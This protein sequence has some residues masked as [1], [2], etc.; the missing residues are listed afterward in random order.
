MNTFVYRNARRSRVEA[1]LVMLGDAPSDLRTL[2]LDE[3]DALQAE[4]WSVSDRTYTAVGADWLWMTRLTLKLQVDDD[5]VNLALGEPARLSEAQAASVETLPHFPGGPPPD[6]LDQVRSAVDGD[7]EILAELLSA[8][9]RRWLLQPAAERPYP[10]DDV[11]V[12][13]P[14]RLETLFDRPASEYN[15][16]PT[17]WRLSLRVIPDEASICRD[18]AF[19]SPDERKAATAFWNAVQQPGDPGPSWLDGEDAAVAWGQFCARVTPARAAWLIGELDAARVGE[20]IAVSLPPAMPPA[21]QPNRVGG[22]PPEL[23]VIITTTLAV[24]GLTEHA[25]GRLPMAPDQQI[26]A[27]RL[28]LPVPA[29]LDEERARWWSNWAEAKAVGL[30]GEWLLPPGVTPQNIETL[31]VVGIGDERPEA[32][33]KA[34]IDA[35]ELGVLRLGAPTNT[36]HGRPA[37]DLG[38]ANADWLAVAQARLRQKAAPEQSILSGVGRTL[39]H[40]LVGD[41][42]DLPFFPGADVADDTTLSQSMVKAL[43]PALWGQWMTQLWQLDA[44][45]YRVGAWMM[46]HFCPEGPLMPLRIGE[47]PYGL[48]PVTALSQWRT[49]PVFTPEAQAQA[50]VESAMAASLHAVCRGLAYDAEQRR[51]AM[52]KSTASFMQNLGHTALSADYIVRSFGPAWAFLA[53]LAIQVGLNPALFLG[54]QA[55]APEEQPELFRQASRAYEPARALMQRDP[56]DI[57]LASGDGHALDMPLVQPPAMTYRLGFHL[58]RERYELTQLLIDVL[59]GRSLADLFGDEFRLRILPYSLLIRLL[60]HAGQAVVPWRQAAELPRAQR[61]IIEEQE[62]STL[63]IGQWLDQPQWHGEEVDPAT[64]QVRSFTLNLPPIWRAD[65]ERALRATLDSASY[66]IDPWITGFAWQRLKQ[67]SA[68]PRR[69]QRL[70]VYGW[71]DGPFEGA[72]GPNEY[73]RLHTPSYNQT[74]AA[75]ILRD[76]FLSAQRLGLN[77]EDGDNPWAMNIGS[78]SVRL[79]EEIAD[80]VRMG[81][82][83]YEIV[84]RHVEHV[85]ADQPGGPEVVRQLRLHPRYAMRPERQ[86]PHEVCNGIAALRSLLGKD[87]ALPQGD[88]VFPLRESQRR[89]LQRIDAALDAY[90]DLL[91]AD[92]TMQLVNRQPERA[93]ESMDAASGFTRPPAFEFTRTPPSGY[94]LESLVLC[95]LP[96]RSSAGLGS[97]ADPIR[98]ADASVA[99][100][101]DAQLGDGWLWRAYAPDD[102]ETVIGSI[103]LA[104]LGFAPHETLALSEQM[105]CDLAQLR[106]G[107]VDVR[108]AAPRQHGLAQEL[109]RAL[110]SRPLAG[111]DLGGD[112]KQQRAADDLAYRELRS[113]YVRLYRNCTTLATRLRTAKTDGVRATLLR[114]A[115]IWGVMPAAETTDRDALYALLAGQPLPPGSPTTATL[116]ERAAEVLEQ[117][118]RLAP[119]PTSL[120]SAAELARPLSDDAQ[121]KLDAIPDGIPSLATAIANLASPNGRLAILACW[122]R[123]RLLAVS[124]LEIGQP[125]TLLDE[126]WLTVTAATRA[127]LA[128]LEAIQLEIEP[129]LIAWSSSPG[130]PWQKTL[131]AENLTRRDTPH[132]KR[133]D[134]SVLGLVTRPFVAGYGVD[135]AWT[136][137]RVAAGMIDAFG[138][139]IPMPQRTSTAAFGFNAPAARPPQAI[140]LAVPPTPRQRLEN[141]LLHRIVA[142]TRQLAHARV[143]RVEELGDLQA[144]APTTWLPM[145]GPNRFHLD[146]YPTLA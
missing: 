68:G 45:G 67:Q 130:D 143:A 111:R 103:S 26:A 40:F 128:R 70:G 34:Q 122:T 43:W 115:L 66:R 99:A 117:R 84:G 105:L 81:F 135:D 2:L 36:V 89:A 102:G 49:L 78:Q 95:A 107:L 56:S 75:L 28:L 7:E 76:Q 106:L 16:D 129:P 48:L 33:F 32:H 62:R 61:I 35:G 87:P 119:D 53:P 64:D 90:G 14:L 144:L 83:I 23:Q 100:F 91:M 18:D 58:E 71:V 93:A 125:D 31:Y 44:E 86:D 113:R 22:M 96:Y 94:Q 134:E 97:T 131:V 132:E 42:P 47:Q 4:D 54:A 5:P 3:L 50:Q 46:Q 126:S 77:S 137:D 140:L 1:A 13:L 145:S 10:F 39:Q 27:E 92:G 73:G 17:S 65:L 104:E 109:V 60:I 57:F 51:S 59:E 112:S 146:P 6:Y 24:D 37:A 82:H 19:V 123:S 101:L 72:P 136:G 52:E 108:M 85:M 116:T 25:I 41:A 63:E 139:A 118:L 55:L 142:E 15:D 114:R 79:A 20:R 69:N 120:P 30:G 21:P 121:R 29:N 8:G 38:Q 127:E 9:H 11:G 98:V 12:L 74:L 124:K 110:G 141:A 133:A 138:E 80:E 88:P